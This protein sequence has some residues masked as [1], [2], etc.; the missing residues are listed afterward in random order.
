M[1]TID[2]LIQ[3][4]YSETE[5]TELVLTEVEKTLFDHIEIDTPENHEYIN[6]L[7]ETTCI[8]CPN[9]EKARLFVRKFLFEERFNNILGLSNILYIWARDRDIPTLITPALDTS[10]FIALNNSLFTFVSH[11]HFP[12]KSCASFQYEGEFARAMVHFEWYQVNGNPH[13]HYRVTP[14]I[15]PLY[16]NLVNYEVNDFVE[17]LGEHL[18]DEVPSESCSDSTLLRII[19]SYGKFDQGRA[20]SLLL[21]FLSDAEYD[22]SFSKALNESIALHYNDISLFI[23]SQKP[24]VL[25]NYHAL[26][27]SVNS[28]NQV[29]FEELLSQNMDVNQTDDKGNTVAFSIYLNYVTETN[30]NFSMFKQLVSRGLDIHH[31][32]AKGET[33]ILYALDQLDTYSARVFIKL[34]AE[35][36]DVDNEGN[37][38]VERFIIKLNLMEDYPEIIRDKI[39]LF[40]NFLK[41]NKSLLNDHNLQQLESFCLKYGL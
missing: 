15:D 28:K 20:I 3:Q 39:N 16:E 30:D 5:S 14:D 10:T 25:T 38:V 32:N 35:V 18:F 4:L 8:Y 9:I 2:Q 33:P 37:G 1:L 41:R 17:K 26:A 34:G 13:I 24:C 31:A 11:E 12:Y 7:V 6:N 36:N 27:A 22:A 40:I 21:P 19:E 29:V 23:L